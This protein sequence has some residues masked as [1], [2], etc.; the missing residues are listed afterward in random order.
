MDTQERQFEDARIG[1]IQ[2]KDKTTDVTTVE[3]ILKFCD[4][5]EKKN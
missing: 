2:R 3:E 5:Y 1:A 4:C